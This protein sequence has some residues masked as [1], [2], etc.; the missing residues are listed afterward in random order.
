MDD[1]NRGGRMGVAKA[2]D[3]AFQ[4]ADFDGGHH[5]MWVID[6]MVQALTGDAYEAWVKNYEGEDEE[7]EWDR[8][9]AP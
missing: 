4:Y 9:I 7:Y 8:G 3:I 2:L 6:Q 5:K 1:I